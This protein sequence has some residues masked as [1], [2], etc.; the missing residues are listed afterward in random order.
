MNKQ[1]YHWARTYNYCRKKHCQR[2]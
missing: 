1:K 2:K